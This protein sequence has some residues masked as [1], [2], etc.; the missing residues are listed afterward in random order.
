MLSIAF[1]FITKLIGSWGTR[2]MAVAGEVTRHGQAL[3]YSWS[4]STV[5]LRSK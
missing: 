4:V 1:S 3:P 5:S 2:A